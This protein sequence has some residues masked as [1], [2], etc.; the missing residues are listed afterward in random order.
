[1]DTDVAIIGAGPAG[2]ALACGLHGSGL[3]VTLF[4]KAPEASLAEPAS[5]GREIALTHRSQGILR[6][7]GA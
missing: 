6:D 1:M 5:D 7:L 2:L 3:S 4:E